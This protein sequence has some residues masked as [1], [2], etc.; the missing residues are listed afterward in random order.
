MVARLNLFNKITN[1]QRDRRYCQP[2]KVVEASIHSKKS[3][4]SSWDKLSLF[5]RRSRSLFGSVKNR[6]TLISAIVIPL[7]SLCNIYLVDVSTCLGFACFTHT[8]TAHHLIS[9]FRKC[10]NVGWLRFSL[11]HDNNNCFRCVFDRT[12]EISDNAPIVFTSSLKY[13]TRQ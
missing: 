3:L 9:L 7:A 5:R 12:S 4:I 6:A 11:S 1:C 13:N 8:H 2:S 10:R